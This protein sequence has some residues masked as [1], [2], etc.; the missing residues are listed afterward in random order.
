MRSGQDIHNN[1]HPKAAVFDIDG[2]LLPGKTAEVEFVKYLRRHNVIGYR[3][4]SA[5]IF[6]FA[7][8]LPLTRKRLA[9]N[10]SQYIRGVPVD[11]VSSL[12]DDFY[13]ERIH[14]SLSGFLLHRMEDLRSSG[15]KIIVISGTLDL[16]VQQMSAALNLD[17]DR[18]SVQERDGARFTGNIIGETP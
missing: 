10:K 1:H 17:Y 13:R 15:Y 12:M 7:A 6:R 14:P 9:G 2:T 5:G 3:N 16:I 4:L 8:G 11:R 18:G